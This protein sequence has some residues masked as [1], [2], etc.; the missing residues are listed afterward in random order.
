M[1]RYGVG[2]L[3]LAL[4]SG[5]GEFVVTLG[6]DGLFFA[7]KFVARGDVADRRM[8]T[9]GWGRGGTGSGAKGAGF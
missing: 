7:K 2:G 4:K 1:R 3:M 8:E 9:D 6:K 5:L